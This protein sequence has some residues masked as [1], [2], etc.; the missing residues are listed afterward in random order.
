MADFKKA[1]AITSRIEA[2]YTNNSKDAGKETYRGISI[3]NN[4]DWLGWEVVHSTIAKLG[5]SSTL[6]A[7]KDVYAEIDKALAD[8]P[9]IDGMVQTLYKKRYW[10]ILNLDN[11]ASQELA[12]KTFDIA[13]NMGV[14]AARK[15]YQDSQDA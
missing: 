4:P 3:V 10:D 15:A 11:E 6:D 9:Y 8:N 12:N 13:V 2:G 7:A 5:I 14:G 1:W